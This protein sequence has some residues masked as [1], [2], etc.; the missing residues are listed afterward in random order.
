MYRI[1]DSYS[2]EGKPWIERKPQINQACGFYDDCQ[3]LGHVSVGKCSAR[4]C[5][6]L[7]S[8]DRS[9]GNLT[10]F[11]DPAWLI[12]QCWIIFE[13][14]QGK[15]HLWSYSSPC[16]GRRGWDFS[17]K[18]PATHL[19]KTFPRLLTIPMVSPGFL[20]TFTHLSWRMLCLGPEWT[21]V[22]LFP[23]VSVGTRLFTGA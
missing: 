18:V 15:A 9:V 8:A 21:W 2:I 22:S 11:T 16:D 1:R 5:S 20:C 23:A 6:S 17:H 4:V 14:P 12:W 13:K 10:P 3:E 19:N 7:S